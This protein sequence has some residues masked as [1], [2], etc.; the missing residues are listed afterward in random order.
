MKWRRWLIAFHR[1]LGYFFTGVILLYSISGIAVNH[2][3]DWNPNFDIQ[4]HDVQ[5]DLSAEASQITRQQVV[6]S[7][8][9]I[10]HSANF[11]S[12]DF[13]SS[14]KIKIYLDDGDI[15]ASLRDGRGTRETI[16]RRPLLYQANN[17]HLNP[18]RW[19]KAF[20]DVFAVALIVLASTGL[21]VLRGRHGLLG[22]GKWLVG[23]GLLA[24]LFAIFL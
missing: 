2:I 5:L 19:W 13:P 6:T 17:L 10:G 9:K 23:A 15:M 8:G 14:G 12:F 7:L 1:D 18:T 20:S 21:V 16:R 11:R 22:R 3:D 4:R 24:P